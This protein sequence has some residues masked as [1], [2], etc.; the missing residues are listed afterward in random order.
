[1][2]TRQRLCMTFIL[3]A[4]PDITEMQINK[5]RD[6][7]FSPI[8]RHQE[9]LLLAKWWNTMNY[10]WWRFTMVYPC[11]KTIWQFSFNITVLQ[12]Y[13]LAIMFLMKFDSS[14]MEYYANQNLNERSLFV[15][16]KCW[17]LE[18][19]N[20]SIS[21]IEFSSIVERSIY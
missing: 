19:T 17:K 6:T 13:C 16:A 9:S 2:L 3:L 21:E 7:I 15:I 10:C 11:K 5:Q 1:M 4:P 12:P 20:V 18:P 8:K 14:T